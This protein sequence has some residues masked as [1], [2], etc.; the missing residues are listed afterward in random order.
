[1]VFTREYFSPAGPM[2]L[3]SDGIS[4]T[5]LWFEGQRYFPA[6]ICRR[7]ADIPVLDLAVSWLEIY[8]SGCRPS[9]VPEIRFIGT[10]FRKKVWNALL[11]IPYGT[12]VTY[13]ELTDRVGC[14][15]ARA[16]GA[17]VGHN[18][19]SVIVPCHRVVGSDGSLTG[20]AG[21]L[22]RK[23]MLLAIESGLPISMTAECR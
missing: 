16:V 1:M 14:S 11:D 22:D 5:G 4:L 17:A 2:L 10:D 6:D 23:S 3:A 19:V 8:F 21:G 7:E 13:G 20:Y 15:S 12:T 9:F 18:P